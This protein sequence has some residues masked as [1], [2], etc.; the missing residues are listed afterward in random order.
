M[1]SFLVECDHVLGSNKSFQRPA[2][3]LVGVEYNGRHGSERVIFETV[4]SSL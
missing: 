2:R 4:E 1:R 3:L